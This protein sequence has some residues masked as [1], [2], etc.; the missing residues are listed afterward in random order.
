LSKLLAKL[1]LLKESKSEDIK[2][3]ETDAVGFKTNWWKWVSKI[4]IGGPLGEGKESGGETKTGDLPTVFNTWASKLTQKRMGKV[5]GSPDQAQTI[6]QAPE[7]DGETQ[8][9]KIIV[10]NSTISGAT[11][12]NTM[13]AQGLAVVKQEA[14]AASS[15]GPALRAKE[16]KAISIHARFVE[17]SARNDA[18]GW[19]RFRCT[20]LQEG[21]GNMRDA[22]YYSRSALESAITIFEGKKI[23]ADH[24]S[25][26]E[27]VTRP[28]RSVKDVLGHFENLSLVTDKDSGQSH[29]EAD[30]VIL[31]DDSFRW[32][33][34]LLRHA[35]EFS[36]KFPD[37]E[38]VGLS[39]NASGSAE[40]QP[41]DQ[42]IEA[43]PQ[44]AK[45]KLQ[46]AKLELG[47]D[48]IRVVSKIEDAISCDLVTE[49]GAGG[50]IL[51][52]IEQEKNMKKKQ[53]KESDAE[54]KKE[55]EMKQEESLPPV[56]DDKKDAAPADG[57]EEKP[58]GDE[59]QDIELIKKMIAQY[60]GDAGG[61]EEMEMAMEA[62][63]S[64]KQMEYTEDE[65][66][67]CAAHAV[68]LAKHMAGK[69]SEADDEKKDAGPIAGDK[70]EAPP[71]EEE[72]SP[73]ESES[74][75]CGDKMESE[76]EEKKEKKESNQVVELTGKLALLEGQIKAFQIR[77]HLD[78]VCRES[79][80]G[81]AATKKFQAL[82]AVKAAKTE[83]EI[84]KL[85]KVFKEAATHGGEADEKYSF[86]VQTEKVNLQSGGKKSLSFED[87]VK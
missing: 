46:Q 58:H 77:D 2:P 24:P 61:D 7:E 54:I 28:E 30:V 69:K 15:N 85:F 19:T 64:F 44:G 33:R 34:G 76:S 67:K 82:E 14:D 49:A 47:I 73:K 52:M 50:K 86:I 72:K 56:A 25:E 27:S 55:A 10:D 5:E 16:S 9:R 80:L 31:P 17:S 66:L 42:V 43:A 51:T 38:F 78:K 57:A 22:F 53:I 41:I 60:L 70:K 21:M 40:P 39:I 6:A 65:A 84:D 45:L 87:C 20:L 35:V 63:H 3:I 1:L 79:G 11:L 36:K 74:K 18:V 83:T 8:A 37:K 26:T 29:L 32:A 68:K 13:K 62:Y 48:Q 23:Y 81:M 71:K 12:L 59:E 4:P 75:E